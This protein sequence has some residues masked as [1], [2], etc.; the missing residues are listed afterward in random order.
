M[1]TN[2]KNT[3]TLEQLII[4]ISSEIMYKRYQRAKQQSL[5]L[6]D[7]ESHNKKGCSARAGK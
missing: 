7:Q 4:N 6:V 3:Q 5:G 2:F 1:K